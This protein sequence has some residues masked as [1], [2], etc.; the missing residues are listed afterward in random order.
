MSRLA[1][2]HDFFD[3]RREPIPWDAQR[4][5]PYFNERWLALAIIHGRFWSAGP[6]R[7]L[8][9][10]AGSVAATYKSTPQVACGSVLNCTASSRQCAS[11]RTCALIATLSDQA[12]TRGQDMLRGL[13]RS[14]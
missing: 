10:C 14:T 2:F 6:D 13:G 4:P 12:S 11:A 9:R 1:F 8:A 3:Q 7:K 5:C